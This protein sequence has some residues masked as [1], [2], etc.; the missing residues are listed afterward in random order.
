MPL[1]ADYDGKLNYLSN[2]TSVTITKFITLDSTLT[3]NDD[4]TFNCSLIFEN[5]PFKPINCLDNWQ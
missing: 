3:Y 5:D 1:I 4:F 2:A